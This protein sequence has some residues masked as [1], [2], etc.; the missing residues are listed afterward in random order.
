M[1]MGNLAG[2]AQV[3]AA[4]VTVLLHIAPVVATVPL[5]CG[6]VVLQQDFDQ[7][8]GPHRCEISRCFRDLGSVLAYCMHDP[9]MSLPETH[10]TFSDP[11]G[12]TTWM[13]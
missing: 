11:P 12:V 3:A 5:T 8:T 4:V 10:V 7:Y 13:S 6:A 2:R 9:H 1:Q